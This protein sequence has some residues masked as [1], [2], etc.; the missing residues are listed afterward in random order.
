MAI[1]KF[2]FLALL[3]FT[4]VGAISIAN[5]VAEFLRPDPLPPAS[6]SDM[7]P[8][9]EQISATDLASKVVPFRSDLKADYARALA[10][11]ALHTRSREGTEEQKDAQ[12][13]ITG[14]LGIGPHVSQLWLVLA[15]L[16]TRRSP[17]DPLIAQSLKMSYLTGLN[18][19]PLIPIRLG[20]VTSN[21]SLND[22]ELGLLARSDVRALLIHLP[23]GR[24]ELSGDYQRAS[25]VGK[26]FL[27]ETVAAIDPG[28]VATLH[29]K[30]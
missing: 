16:Q 20:V 30:K 22:S 18:Q 21:N 26:R 12:N 4:V 11:A 24:K 28:F 13:A 23:D 15:M 8:L 1:W 2:R 3:L 19:A 29:D 17:V 25:E 27:E 9:P 14:A 6:R 7:A 5:L 10:G